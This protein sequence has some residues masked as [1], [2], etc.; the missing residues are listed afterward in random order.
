MTS[1]VLADDAEKTTSE[2]RDIDE[3][4]VEG[5]AERLG[6]P[7]VRVRFRLDELERYDSYLVQCPYCN[8]EKHY[9]QAQQH[10]RVTLGGVSPANCP[11]TGQCYYLL[12]ASNGIGPATEIIHSAR[13]EISNL[14]GDKLHQPLIPVG[15]DPRVIDDL[16]R[17]WS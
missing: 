3:F 9:H 5:S 16:V 11:E 8:G 2:K 4:S 12:L 1:E 7:L 10:P 14:P 13:Q 15:I 6:H 17:D